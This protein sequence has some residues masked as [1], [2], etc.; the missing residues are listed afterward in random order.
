MPEAQSC[1][2][3]QR[4]VLAAPNRTYQRARVDLFA[5]TAVA[6]NSRRMM[7][8]ASSNDA[9]ASEP[10]GNRIRFTVAACI[11]AL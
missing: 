6:I 7:R 3:R 4:V 9:P 5:A 11:T 2:C 8:T 1:I 10:A